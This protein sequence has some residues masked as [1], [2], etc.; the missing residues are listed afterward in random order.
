MKKTLL[1]LFLIVSLFSCTEN[2]R[3]RKFGGNSEL[4]L[5][6]NEKLVNISWKGDELWVLTTEMEVDYK[7]KTYTFIEKSKYGIL[8]GEIKIVEVK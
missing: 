7:P 6:K 5:N 3:I 4:I 1:V 8:E 2:T